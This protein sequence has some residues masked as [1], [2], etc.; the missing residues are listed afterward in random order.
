MKKLTL[1]IAMVPLLAF[2]NADKVNLTYKGNGAGHSGT[3]QINGKKLNVGIVQQKFQFAGMIKGSDLY[4]MNNKVGNVYCVDLSQWTDTKNT[5]CYT[6]VTADALPVVQGA[7]KKAAKLSAMNCLW[8]EGL[9]GQFGNAWTTSNS[10]YAAAFQLMNWELMTDFD[11][12]LDSIKL[13]SGSFQLCS[14]LPAG[15][16]SVFNALKQNMAN[17]DFKCNPAP[18]RGL[19]N[20]CFQ[21]YVTPVPEPATMAALGLG[22]AAAIR[23][24]K[25]K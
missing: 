20:D 25:A 16:V 11:G 1:F 23:R 2:A 12:T 21:D 17:K 4:S 15:A 5:N 24:R 8:N 13:D 10:D 14:S 6:I 9:G 19:V 7:P 18:V 22:A 3:I